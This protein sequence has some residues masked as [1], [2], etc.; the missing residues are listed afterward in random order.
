M[1]ADYLKKQGN[2]L[3]SKRSSVLALWQQIAENFYPERADFTGARNAGGDL[4]KG[5]ATGYPV[6]MRR[7]LGDS[8]GSMLRPTSKAWA[9]ARVANWDD[10]STEARAWLEIREERMRHEMNQADTQFTRATKQADHDFAAFGQAVIQ[11][12]LNSKA[13]GLLYR[14]W[15]L[16]DVAWME[17]TDGG[18]G[19]VYRKWKATAA[20]LQRFFPKT[21]HPSVKEKLDKDPYCEFEI[22]HCVIESDVYVDPLGKKYNTPF[23]SVYLDVKNAHI[24]EEVGMKTNEYV[25]PRWS[26]VS[27][28]QYAY[29]P[30]V[31]VGLAD[32]RTLQEMTI[33]LLEA[34]EKAVTP[35]ML[36]V[37]G[38]LR[39]D[40]N[41]MAG[42]LT[43]V[44]R[45]YDERLG[46]VLRPLTQDK[47]GIPIGFNMAQDVRAQLHE[48]FYLS[49]LSLPPPQGEMTAYETGQRVQEYIRHALP[50][51]Q[52][53]EMEYNA[54]ICENT[55]D[56]LLLAGVFGSPWD[57]PEELRNREVEFTFES[58]LHDAI[59]REKGQRFLEATSIIAN[60]AAADPSVAHLLDVKLATRDVLQSTGVPTTWLRSK[61]AVDALVEQDKQ[62]QQTAALL[63]QM[64]QGAKVAQLIGQT[65]APS[66]T[67]NTG[68]AI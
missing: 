48:A 56:R 31:V 44:D 5:L 68:A 63:Q 35:P 25:I 45:E 46:E 20:D 26:L 47:S 52:P 49:K 33:T 29:S 37:H 24:M 17:N 12:S 15:H 53:L 39:S 61:P 8:I 58:P 13:N 60:G 14:C 9:H 2:E 27:G 4:A 50:L 57:I 7:D 62:A 34:G 1:L 36:A 28:S 65:A 64:E 22:W 54:P 21:L 43:W 42:G 23:I 41:V 32:A 30:A 3:F 16:R 6:L 66:G 51:F 19:C 18:I 38:A 40:V 10:V 59:E 11:I 67:L 55:F